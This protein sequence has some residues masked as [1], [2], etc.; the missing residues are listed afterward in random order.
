MWQGKKVSVVF[1]TYREKGSIRRMIDDY[2][3]T[4]FV[5]EVVVVNNNAEPGTD[6]EVKKTKARLVYENKQGYGH[7]YQRGIKEATGD[8]IFLSE[9]D[10]TYSAADLEKFLVYSHDFPVVMGT[11]TNRSAILDG[12]SMGLIRKLANVFEA[13]VIEV[14]FGT[15]SLTEIGCTCKLFE[16]EVLLSLAPYWRTTNALFATELLLLVVSKKIKFIEIPISFSERIGKS[17][18]TAKWHQL[19]KWGLKIFWFILSFWL[20]WVLGKHRKKI[21]IKTS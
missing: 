20:G 21:D 6:E 14:F 15:N 11:R 3:A 2:F 12:A 7:G 8:Y 5:D 9:P 18:L 19:A 10:G 13:K 16:K 4:G 1:S 17:Q